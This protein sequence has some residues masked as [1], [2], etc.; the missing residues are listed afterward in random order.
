MF[1][2]INY[3][4]KYQFFVGEKEYIGNLFYILDKVIKTEPDIKV[5]ESQLR[6]DIAEKYP[7][8]KLPDDIVID[9]IMRL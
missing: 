9:N 3:L 2:K 8:I 4:I 6:R 5:L 1:R 7:K